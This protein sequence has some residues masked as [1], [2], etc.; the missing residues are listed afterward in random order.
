V[1]SLKNGAMAAFKQSEKDKRD[2]ARIAKLAE[3]AKK[4]G[5]PSIE[6]QVTSYLKDLDPSVWMGA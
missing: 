5:A 6:E 4:S 3:K 2:A 1:Q